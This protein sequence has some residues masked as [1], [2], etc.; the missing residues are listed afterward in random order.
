VL[1][2]GAKGEIDVLYCNDKLVEA[3]MSKFPEAMVVE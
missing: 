3:V 2:D 1:G